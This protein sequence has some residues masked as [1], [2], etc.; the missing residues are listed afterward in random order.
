MSPIVL[1]SNHADDERDMVERAVAALT[2]GKLVAFPT[3]TVY[4]IA[5]SALDE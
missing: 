3:E 4:G 1:V 2:E 5:A